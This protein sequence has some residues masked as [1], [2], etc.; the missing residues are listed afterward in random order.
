[1]QMGGYRRRVIANLIQGISQ[2]RG[3]L[4]RYLARDFPK[5]NEIF[6]VALQALESHGGIFVT[7]LCELVKLLGKVCARGFHHDFGPS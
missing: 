6:V 5:L 3:L 4:C 7:P 1:M 2:D